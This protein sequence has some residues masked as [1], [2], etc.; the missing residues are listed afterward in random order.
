MIAEK[1]QNTAKVTRTRRAAEATF[2]SLPKAGEAAGQSPIAQHRS[3]IQRRR[4]TTERREVVQRIEDLFVAAVAASMPR[5]HGAAG[6]H[7]LAE[8]GGRSKTTIQTTPHQAVDR[9]WDT[10]PA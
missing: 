8:R 7:A 2:E 5:H 4:S 1:L 9:R 3:V 6:D 10:R